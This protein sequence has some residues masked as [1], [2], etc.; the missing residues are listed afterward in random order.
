VTVNGSSVAA[1]F[2]GVVRGGQYRVA[3]RVVADDGHPETGDFGF[4]YAAA[5]S[6]SAPAQPGGA[7]TEP[8][9]DPV[10]VSQEGSA[11]DGS[12]VPWV[13][14]GV[15]AVVV[16]AIVALRQVRTVRQGRSRAR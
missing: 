13:L 4:T 9:A 12:G 3:W 2:P 7:S 16:L 10:S 11:E 6:P 1:T 14:V 8:A 5:S 15:G